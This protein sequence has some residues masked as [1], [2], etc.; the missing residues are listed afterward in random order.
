MCIYYIT[1]IKRIDEFFFLIK[2][3]MSNFMV[4]SVKKESPSYAG[5]FAYYSNGVNKVFAGDQPVVPLPYITEALA[6][7][8]HGAATKHDQKH[9]ENTVKVN[10]HECTTKCADGLQACMEANQPM[11]EQ[12]YLN[13]VQHSCQ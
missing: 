10:N 1:T 2:L 12:H 11:C 13:C 4:N 7:A 8:E 9:M 6:R 5:P 3:K